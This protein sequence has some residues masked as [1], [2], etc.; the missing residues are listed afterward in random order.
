M[1]SS[2]RLGGSRSSRSRRP[3]DRADAPVL[4]GYAIPPFYDSMVGKFIVHGA[5][6]DEAQSRGRR[7]F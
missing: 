6:R 1:T 4:A 3:G 2:P 7:A 5:D